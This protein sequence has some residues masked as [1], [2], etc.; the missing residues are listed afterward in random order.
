M[1][2]AKATVVAEAAEQPDWTQKVRVREGS[3]ETRVDVTRKDIIVTVGDVSTYLTADMS[4]E[5]ESA[6]R[7]GRERFLAL[8]ELPVFAK[9]AG[10][11]GK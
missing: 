2:K 9:Q 4:R 8:Q 7:E 1:A 5:M 11:K 6:V 3:P 10:K